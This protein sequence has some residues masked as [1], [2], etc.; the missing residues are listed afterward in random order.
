MWIE[1]I[2]WSIYTVICM[3]QNHLLMCCWKMEA[4]KWESKARHF[5]LSIHTY[6]CINFEQ[7]RNVKGT[8]PKLFSCFCFL[9]GFGIHLFTLSSHF[10]RCFLLL[11]KCVCK[12]II[13]WLCAIGVRVRAL[14]TFPFFP[15]HIGIIWQHLRSIVYFA[16][17]FPF[18]L[19]KY[20]RLNNR[21][22]AHFT[23]YLLYYTTCYFYSTS[24]I[25]IRIRKINK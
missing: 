9:F 1:C 3:P 6:G 13:K 2:S 21:N 24:N 4:E 16:P 22:H 5:G 7:N 20:I 15:N 8:L 14:I 18:G 10:F 12:C 11:A 23:D 19:K 25:H 17:L